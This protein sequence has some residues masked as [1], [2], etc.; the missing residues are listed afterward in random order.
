MNLI[1]SDLTMTC[2]ACPLQY[3]GTVNGKPFYYRGRWGG[4]CFGVGDTMNGKENGAVGVA[5]G[6]LDGFQRQGMGGD[7]DPMEAVA[8]I[9][10]CCEEWFNEWVRA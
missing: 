10:Q 9:W 4:W 8:N 5:M 2:E 1:I 7:T 3:E 6:F